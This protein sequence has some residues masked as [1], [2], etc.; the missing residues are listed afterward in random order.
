MLK[1]WRNQGKGVQNI[2]NSTKGDEYIVAGAVEKLEYAL[3]VK[4][5]NVM[6]A[7]HLTESLMWVLHYCKK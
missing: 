7:E 4:E 3:Y 5:V 2:L 1:S 6:L